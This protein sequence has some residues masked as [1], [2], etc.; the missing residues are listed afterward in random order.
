MTDPATPLDSTR[1]QC[2]ELTLAAHQLKA[3]A[4]SIETGA[5]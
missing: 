4:Q 1:R 2:I 5:A 3:L